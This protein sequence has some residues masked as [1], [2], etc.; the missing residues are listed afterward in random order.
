M[1]IHGSITTELPGEL[2]GLAANDQGT[3]GPRTGNDPEP[4]EGSLNSIKPW[5]NDGKMMGN[6]S[7]TRRIFGI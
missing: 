1:E 4:K 5:E 7:P 6:I 2:G 3:G